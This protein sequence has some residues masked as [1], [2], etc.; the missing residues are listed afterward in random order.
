MAE[1]LSSEDG[2]L[3]KFVSQNCQR[4]MTVTRN[5]TRNAVVGSLVTVWGTV[6]RTGKRIGNDLLIKNATVYVIDDIADMPGLGQAMEDV[7]W[8]V[9]NEYGL[10]F[11]GFFDEHNVEPPTSAKSNADR[12]R[13]FRERKKNASQTPVTKSNER[14]DREEKRREEVS[15]GDSVG[16]CEN[17]F[18]TPTDT[19]EQINPIARYPEHVQEQARRILSGWHFWRYGSL[20]N[21][22]SD[23]TIGNLNTIAAT[24][25]A[26]GDSVEAKMAE[27]MQ[28]PPPGFPRTAPLFRIFKHLGLEAPNHEPVQPPRRTNHAGRG[29]PMSAGGGRYEG[30]KPVIA[31]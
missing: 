3:A 31:D 29:S 27:F 12:Q 23:S 7:G 21:L 14:N 15:I 5:V 22:S 25:E 30:I 26:F 28:K 16:D 17:P 20:P 10:V 9:E 13:A 4:D 18:T 6:R 8:A 24:V 11:P 1:T 19:P 2:C